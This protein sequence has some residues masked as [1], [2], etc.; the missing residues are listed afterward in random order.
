MPATDQRLPIVSSALTE[1]VVVVRPWQDG[2]AA[3]LYEAARESIETVG[4][5]LSWLDGLYAPA[6]ALRWVEDSQARWNRGS[7]FRFAVF[8]PGLA[9]RFVGSAGLNHLNDVHRIA[10]LGYWV[11]ASAT[12]RG[13]ASRAARLVAQFGLG[14]AGLG[15]IELLTAVDNIASQRVADKVGATYEGTLRDRLLVRGTRIPARLYSLVA[16]DLPAAQA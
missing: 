15:R 13:I 5:W 12:G 2:D 7:E 1:G 8:E 6:D 3:A 10:N 9:G 4:P 16:G 11:R 14:A